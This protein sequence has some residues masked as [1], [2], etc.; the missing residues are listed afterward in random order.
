MWSS[1]FV[2]TISRACSAMAEHSTPITMRAPAFAA[3]MERMPVPQPTSSTTFPRKRCPFSMM[4]VWY[5]RVR[6]WSLSISS[7]MPK[8]A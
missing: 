3:N 7:W 4:A 1:S 8:C 5:A 6:A 2:A